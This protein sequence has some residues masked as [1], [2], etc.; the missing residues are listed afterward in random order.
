VVIVG[1]NAE[2]EDI[3]TTPVSSQFPGA[4]YHATVLEN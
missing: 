2:T 4:E 3:I 1:V